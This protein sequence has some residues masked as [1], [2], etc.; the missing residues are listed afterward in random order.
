MKEEDDDEN[1]QRR[2]QIDVI[3]LLGIQRRLPDEAERPLKDQDGAGDEAG[4][5]RCVVLAD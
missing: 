1:R 3:A 5:E 4:D 2:K